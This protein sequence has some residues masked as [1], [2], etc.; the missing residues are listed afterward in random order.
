MLASSL[1]VRARI[2]VCRAR[3]SWV[4]PAII[5]A[6]AA[7]GISL[8]MPDLFDIADRVTEGIL[9]VPSGSRHVISFGTFTVH[10]DHPPGEGKSCYVDRLI[11]K[12][13]LPDGRFQV[14]GT[15]RE[16][17]DLQGFERI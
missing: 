16:T 2:L 6:P 3:G 9:P 11:Q 5:S 14:Q 4:R 10:T 7:V 8:L 1:G 12:M 15:Y 17:A 13:R